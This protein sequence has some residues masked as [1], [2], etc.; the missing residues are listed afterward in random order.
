MRRAVPDAAAYSTSL[1][2]PPSFASSSS[3]KDAICGTEQA[4][5]SSGQAGQQADQC[6]LSA[7]TLCIIPLRALQQALLRV[8]VGSHVSGFGAPVQDE[9]QHLWC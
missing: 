9:Q 8:A 3:A 6:L 7:P 4:A 5:S 2:A 1:P